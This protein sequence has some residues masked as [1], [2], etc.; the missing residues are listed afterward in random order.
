[1]ELTILY[2]RPGT[3][4]LM[5]VFTVSTLLSQQ[6]GGITLVSSNKGPK[7]DS[8]ASLPPLS[9]C[10]SPLSSDRPGVSLC[11]AIY[12]F[13]TI[14][15]QVLSYSIPVE[16]HRFKGAKGSEFQMHCQWNVDGLFG[17]NSTD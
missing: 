5:S 7:Y 16:F 8:W 13:I 14:S 4:H 6:T 1:M 9:L 17:Q 2:H 15:Q 12:V 10:R 11:A 3:Q